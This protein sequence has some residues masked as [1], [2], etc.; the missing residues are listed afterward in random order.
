MALQLLA[1]LQAVH[2]LGYA[3][4]TVDCRHVL[5]TERSRFRIGSVGVF[6]V[7]E[8][9]SATQELQAGDLHQLGYLLLLLGTR[10]TAV[11]EVPVLR[12][13]YSP[14]FGQLV[15]LL[16]AAQEPASTVLAR[17]TPQLVRT[18]NS[19]F[20][21]ADTFYTMLV[22]AAEAVEIGTG[23]HKW[24]LYAAAGAAGGGE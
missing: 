7:L 23:V 1:A 22:G 3:C 12:A 2:K 11:T 13:R 18:L 24:P 10:G 6:D 16:L 20:A 15:A 4:R 17:C 19:A 5:E 8:P 21:T 14:A 9:R